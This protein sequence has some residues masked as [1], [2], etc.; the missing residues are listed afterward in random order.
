MTLGAL[1]T[2]AKHTGRILWC[3]GYN[4]YGQLGIGNSVNQ[5]LPQ[6]LVS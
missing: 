2:C 4:F 1:H 6:Q 3:W 5:D